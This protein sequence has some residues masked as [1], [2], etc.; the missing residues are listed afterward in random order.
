ML[1]ISDYIQIIEK[2]LDNSLLNKDLKPVGIYEPIKYLIRNGGKRV[3]PIITLMS[4]NLF[5]SNV[6]NAVGPALALELFHN[7]TLL[8]DDIM[9]KA[10]IRRGKP[11]VN[12][13]WNDNTA[14]LS[15]DTMVFL[16]SQLLTATNK[17]SFFD[18]LEVYNTTAIEV[19]EGQQYDAELELRDLNQT[20]ILEDEYIE[21]IRLKTSVLIGACFK[22]GALAGGA[23]LNDA[24]LLYKYGINVGIAYQ[25][26][27]DLLDTFGDEKTFGKKIGGDIVEGKKTFLLVKAL[28]L[29]TKEEADFMKTYINTDFHN[30][31]EK[32]IA[33][34]RLYEKLGVK[35]YAL[36]VMDNYYQ[37]ADLYLQQL[38]VD[39][40]KKEVITDFITSLKK[41]IY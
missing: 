32:I 37:T 40:E 38:P 6:D 9:D 16:A 33:F 13:R 29:A 20:D 15:G 27:D 14:I 8:H 10:P 24:E 19:C 26:Q 12:I 21:M 4:A 41:R 23:S 39:A 30:K 7:F 2:E 28:E 35:E 5:C 34:T 36:R 31:T 25:I 22:I 11:T 3:R 18:I 17:D 1:T